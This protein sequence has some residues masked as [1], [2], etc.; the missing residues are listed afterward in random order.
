MTTT[1]TPVRIGLFTDSHYAR[2]IYGERHC[3]DSLKKLRAC[4]GT[5]N[6][7]DIPVTLNMGDLIDKAQDKETELGYLAAIREVY[8]PCSGKRHYVIGNHDVATLTKAEF[9]KNS[10][11][12]RPESF[13]SFDHQGVHCIILDSNFHAD[14]SDFSAGNFEWDN[15]WLSDAQLSWLIADLAAAHDR[16]ALIFC[17]GNLDDRRWQGSLDPH[18]VRNAE[19]VRTILE[20]AG[21]VRG[22]IQGHYHPGFKTVIGNIPYISLRAMVV[23]AGLS[24]NAFAILSLNEDDSLEIEGFG[25]QPSLRIRRGLS[26]G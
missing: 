21:T 16:R 11:V 23:G 19:K 26:E 13:Y 7:R 25:Q 12:D 4:V 24:Q 9:L 8:D 20:Q 3:V 6:A 5:F 14:G 22:V 10:G 17:H 18:I 15:A 2:L 1:L